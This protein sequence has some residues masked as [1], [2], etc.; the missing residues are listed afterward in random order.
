MIFSSWKIFTR[1]TTLW[2]EIDLSLSS[3][4]SSL[5]F[6]FLTATRKCSWSW[7]I[8][9]GSVCFNFMN[10]WYK[11]QELHFWIKFSL[12]L[13][14]FLIEDV[15]NDNLSTLIN[16]W[17]SRRSFSWER[18]SV[19]SDELSVSCS[20]RIFNLFELISISEFAVVAS[21]VVNQ[22]ISVIFTALKS[23][24]CLVFKIKNKTSWCVSLFWGFALH[25]LRHVFSISN[26]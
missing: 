14:F 26:L 12:T 13:I 1:L 17:E 25:D 19:C 5:Y 2:F 8:V 4:L 6:F 11:L 22:C 10:R 21:R 9:E 18:L 3:V 15:K 7:E 24:R 16:N 23:L 20:D